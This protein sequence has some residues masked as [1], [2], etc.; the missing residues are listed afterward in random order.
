MDHLENERSASAHLDFADIEAK[1]EECFEERALAVRL[2]SEGDDLR[3][4][5]LLSEGHRGRLE[6]I[7]GLEPGLGVGEGDQRRRRH[8]VFCNGTWVGVLSRVRF[9]QWGFGG[10]SEEGVWGGGVGGHCC[11]LK[12]RERQRQRAREKWGSGVLNLNFE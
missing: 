12:K 8:V 2:A 4:W 11:T 7:V 10:C 3:D 1:A 9:S 5:E 6:A